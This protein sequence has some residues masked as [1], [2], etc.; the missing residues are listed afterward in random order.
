MEA[1][2]EVDARKR[3]LRLRAR[4]LRAT[5]TES[6]RRARSE[7][8]AGHLG[9]LHEVAVAAT[10]AAYA[11]TPREV[12]VDLLLRRLLAGHTELLLPWV[13]SAG[14]HLARVADL[15]ADL[16]TGY[17]GVREPRAQLRRAVPPSRAD[18]VLVP[19]LAFDRA[20]RRLGAGGGHL[21]RLLASAGPAPVRIGV[22]FASQLVAQVPTEP[23]DERVHLVVTEAGVVD[24]R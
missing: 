12:D 16:A 1:D 4:G 15:E 14:V 6:D 17:R 11:A 23:H 2:P 3:A 18:V 8:V 24:A 9:A 20:G 13:D 5:L 22:A 21:D 10:V 19:G 7:L